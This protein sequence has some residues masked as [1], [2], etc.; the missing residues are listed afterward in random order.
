MG[1]AAEMVLDGLLDWNGEY[2]GK[3]QY[4]GAY[5]SKKQ[6][7]NIVKV[8]GMVK[9]FATHQNPKNKWKW[10]HR[11]NII[12][13]YGQEEIIDFEGP[14]TCSQVCKHICSGPTKANWNLFKRWLQ[15][16]YPK[17]A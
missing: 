11:Y 7:T 5:Y 14:K 16:Q 4:D 12:M 3:S 10:Q 1:E 9:L 8:D 15:L 17:P 6:H 13:R 2:T